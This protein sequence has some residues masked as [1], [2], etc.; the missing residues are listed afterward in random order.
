MMSNE[1][2]MNKLPPVKAPETA[3]D[4]MDVERLPDNASEDTDEDQRKSAH[5][6]HM[7]A[8]HLGLSTGALDI[9]PQIGS[10]TIR[11]GLEPNKA[12]SLVDKAMG[13]SSC[14]FWISDWTRL[15]QKLVLHIWKVTF[16]VNTIQEFILYHATDPETVEEWD[17][18]CGTGSPEDSM[19][20]YLGENWSKSIWNDCIIAHLIQEYRQYRTEPL[21]STA[22]DAPAPVLHALFHKKIRESQIQWAK[23]QAKVI[24][25]RKET[26]EEVHTRL[27]GS[28]RKTQIATVRRSRKQRVS[29]IGS[30]FVPG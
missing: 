18:S 23:G 10:C 20:L 3:H 29:V 8:S 17:K 5:I 30:A 16:G 7:L 24:D 19:H 26:G 11:K 14:H 25:G 27:E 4:P 2:I 15:Q 1:S 6:L 21:W 28:L 9:A 12:K 22:P 13:V